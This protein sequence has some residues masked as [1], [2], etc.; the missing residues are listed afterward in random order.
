MSA[1]K[2]TKELESIASNAVLLSGEM[3]EILE[4]IGKKLTQCLDLERVNLWLFN[5][6]DKRI[7][8]VGNYT[9]SSDE[10]SQG[11][12]LNMRE[13]PKYY[14]H[15]KSNKTLVVNDVC[16]SP[17]TK[18]I[19]VRYCKPLGIKAMLDIP[20]RIQGELRGVLCYEHINTTREWTDD[21]IHFA[22]AVSQ[23]VAL[24]METTR[25]RRIQAELE[26]AMR[27][28]DL[29]L[30]EMHHRTKNNLSVL[31]SLLRMQRRES[32]NEEVSH[33]LLDCEARIFSMAKI[34]EHLYKSSNYLDIRLDTYLMELLTEN[35]TSS[36]SS[37]GDIVYHYDLDPGKIETSRAIDLGLIVMEVMSNIN[38]HAFNGEMKGPKRVDVKQQVNG[39]RA[40]LQI[41]DNGGG[42]DADKEFSSTLG[43]SLIE[44]LAEQIDADLNIQSSTEGTSYT[45][46]FELTPVDLG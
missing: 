39:K 45:L 7:E 8:C 23:V 27:E 37:A 1:A 22:M 5:E 42:F 29:L 36:N 3:N 30:K 28:K 19:A 41:V 4:E 44:D 10:F 11:Q 46:R 9:H 20:I 34:H 12:T 14:S 35:E 21:E 43:I 31:M 25:R 13:L 24:A 33:I 26:E 6:H 40:M 16:A 15:L 2:Y 18:E 38:K 17:I 32:H